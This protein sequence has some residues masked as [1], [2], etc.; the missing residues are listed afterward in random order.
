MKSRFAAL[1]LALAALI[2]CNRDPNVAKRHYMEMGDRYF[3][4]QQYKQAALLYKNALR[5]DARFGIAYY[6]L[7]L[8]DLKLGQPLPAIGELRRAI[9]LL[10]ANSAERTDANIKLADIYVALNATR[11][12]QYADEVD[13]VAN[14]LL[15]KDPNSFDG[16]RLLAARAFAEARQAYTTNQGELGRTHLQKAIEEFRKADAAKPGQTNIRLALAASLIFNREVPEAEKIYLEL[17]AKDKTLGQGYVDLYRLYVS[18]NRLSD[19]ENILKQAAANNPKE[20]GY[21]TALAE[22]YYRTKRHDDMVKVLEQIKSHA[23]EYPNAYL[24]VGDFYFRLGDGDEAV[25]QYK[26]G[27]QADAKQKSVYQKHEIEVLMH[28]GKRGLAAEVN[29]EI[30][31]DNPKDADARGLQGTLLLDKGEIQKAVSELQSVITGAP[32]NFVAHYNLGRAHAQRREWEQ[33]RQQFAEVIRL[34]PD[35]VPA[36]VELAKLQTARGDYEAALKSSNEILQ[37]DRNN[38]AAR[39]IQ[40][41]S[42]MGLKKYNESRDLLQAMLKADPS[43]TDTLFQLGVVNLADGKYKDAEDAFRK[44]YALEPANSRGLMG[45]VEVYMAQNK[46]DQGIQLLEQEMQKYP[47]RTDYHLALGN[48]AVRAGKY[49]LAIAEF[50]KVLNATDRS[51]KASGDLYLRLGETYRRKGDL[52]NSI[53]ALQNARTSMPDSTVVISTLALALDSAGRKQEAKAAYEQ[54]LKIEPRNGVALNNL[55]FLLAENNGDLDQA[56]TYAQRAKQLLPQL[57]EVSDTLGWIYL[58]KQLTDQAIDQF[59]DIVAK[60][61]QHST[62]RYHLGMAYAQKGDRMKAVQELNV[63]LKSNPARE[64]GEKIRVLLG[65]LGQ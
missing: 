51:S 57:F 43:S 65:K 7:A 2:S 58:K 3:Q 61:P 10:P 24:L 23:K 15:K 54:C 13:A 21:L 39:L 9:E 47:T 18:Q 14:G 59:R 37:W 20:F 48:T 11:E 1:I 30:L 6:K 40:S 49:D 19:A 56:L 55:A 41:A 50:Q 29:Q 12:K 33:A 62:Y 5:R 22:F 35:Y 46:E 64:E 42:L 4:R 8:T 36:R 28:Q 38:L 45:T 31:K 52:N 17:I 44:D 27:M 53:A 60:Q 34:R 26:E 25:R 32:D 16:H 63:A